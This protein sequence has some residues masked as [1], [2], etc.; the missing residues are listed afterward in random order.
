MGLHGM[1]V[2]I[3]LIRLIISPV[4]V[5]A[6]SLVKPAD[7]CHNKCGDVEISYPFGLTKGCSLDDTFLINCSNKVAKTGT[8]TVTNI[9]IEAHDLHIMQF[10]ARDCYKKTGEVEE[11]INASLSTA[12]YTISKFKNKFTVVGCDTSAYLHGFQKGER[13]TIGCTS[14]CNSLRNVVDGSCSG[15][16]CCEV[17]IP[18]G[19]DSISVEVKSF[20]NH[21][22]VSNFNPCGYAFVVEQ[23]KFYFSH[24]YL[25]N[26]SNDKLPMVLKWAVGN[27][28]CQE[29]AKKKKKIVC[30]G[31]SECTDYPTVSGY[32]CNCKSGYRGNPYLSHG[33]QGLYYS[34]SLVWMYVSALMIIVLWGSYF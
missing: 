33:C 27:E 1:L 18:D 2:R 29:A 25:R 19:S 10:V 5:A 11:Q 16:G 7:G 30:K 9:S 8:L 3:S 13:Y 4:L 12:M 31:N 17:A 28:T 6:A 26:L 21:T 20:N 34:I 14:V 23:G 15:V 24:H 32:R 22:N